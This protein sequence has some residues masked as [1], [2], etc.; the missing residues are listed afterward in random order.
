VRAARAVGDQLEML[1]LYREQDASWIGLTYAA[2]GRWSLAPI[3]PD[4]YNG[5]S[6]VMLF[7]AYLGGVTG[8]AR[9]TALARAALATLRRQ[10]AAEPSSNAS[11]GGFDGLGGI[12]YALTHVGAVWN[13]P[14]ALTDAEA[15]VERIP[16]L[17]TQDSTFDILSGAAGCIG[18]LLSLY[19]WTSSERALAVA[20]QCGDWLLDHA[21]PQVRGI[22]WSDLAMAAPPLAGFSHGAAGIAAA[23][24]GLAAASGQARFRTAALDAIC[25]ERTLFVPG[26]ENW[27]DLRLLES[28][29][30]NASGEGR[31]MAAWC[32]GA[33]G[34]GLGRLQALRQ[35]DDAEI[36]AEIETAVKTT[37]AVGFG[38]NHS[39][40]HGE[41]GNLELLLQASLTFEDGALQEQTYRIAANLLDDIDAHG[42]QCGVPFGVETPGLMTG[43]AGVGY[44]LLRLAKP[45]VVPSVLVL[46]PH[47]KKERT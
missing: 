34:I 6:G 23:L 16:A 38:G 20:V 8:E 43:L 21:Q 46:A 25:Y 45:H 29:E 42:W 35:L 24:L 13:D 47:P 36:R 39:L 22:G 17:L 11:I 27:R 31:Y 9:Y 12:I 18:G 7:L 5:L 19:D 2:E 14:G 33:P 44:G 41:L 28:G 3:G 32:H 10:L 30:A 4:L 40:C 37:Q 1:A 26:A 15:L